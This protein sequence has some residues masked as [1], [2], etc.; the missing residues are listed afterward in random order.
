[1]RL[2]MQVPYGNY[3][4]NGVLQW[5]LYKPDD[6]CRVPLS[7]MVWRNGDEASKLE[8]TAPQAAA[9]RYKECQK[10]RVSYERKL[11]NRRRFKRV[12]VQTSQQRFRKIVDEDCSSNLRRILKH[13]HEL[14][15]RDETDPSVDRREEK[16]KRH[17]GLVQLKRN[18]VEIEIL[19]SLA[20]ALKP[21]RRQR[22]RQPHKGS[23]CGRYSSNVTDK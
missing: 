10:W 3:V 2:R 22:Q 15:T 6:R 20:T 17:R 18:S 19:N 7:S 8:Q 14:E 12:Y 16:G 1:M 11:C 4:S 23:F 5:P 9:T 21:R 13:S